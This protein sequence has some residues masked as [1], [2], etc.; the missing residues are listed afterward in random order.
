M[1]HKKPCYDY[2]FNGRDGTY[3]L[4]QI[5]NPNGQSIAA[6]YYWN[7][8]DTGEAVHVEESAR[9][10]CEHLNHWHVGED[11]VAQEV[12]VDI[13]YQKLSYRIATA[14]RAAKR[15]IVEKFR[16]SL[17]NIRTAL[18]SRRETAVI[19][20]PIDVQLIRRDLN[21]DQ[22]WEV[23]QSIDY[24]YTVKSQC[25]CLLR[26]QAEKLFGPAQNIDVLGEAE[27]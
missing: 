17:I 14:L 26:R 2:Q 18:E 20:R 1:K 22:A 23:L 12:W 6:L 16:P 5:I 21:E 8:P 19:W 4:I 7:E 24:E 11:D 9:L 25:E 10:V 27:L 13:Q 3:D 15:A